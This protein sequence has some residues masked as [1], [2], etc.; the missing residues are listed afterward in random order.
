MKKNIAAIAVGLLMLLVGPSNSLSEVSTNALVYQVKLDKEVYA[1][2]EPI[3][4][5]RVLSNQSAAV[6]YI[7]CSGKWHD[8]LFFEGRELKYQGPCVDPLPGRSW[9]PIQPGKSIVWPATEYHFYDFS[10]EGQYT[11]RSTFYGW[12]SLSADN[13]WG[14]LTNIWEGSIRHSDILFRIKR[15]TEAELK[16]VRDSASK[17]E[18]AAIQILGAHKDVA[19]V[20]DLAKALQ[21][22]DGKKQGQA[23]KALA[24]I[25]TSEAV[26]ALGNAAMKSTDFVTRESIAAG[27]GKTGN[28]AAIPWLKELLKDNYSEVDVT[29]T[30]ADEPLA[31]VTFSDWRHH[32]PAM[33]TAQDCVNVKDP[34]SIEAQRLSCQGKGFK[35]IWTAKATRHYLVRGAAKLALKALGVVDSTPDEEKIPKK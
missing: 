35:G 10:R 29:Y 31:A 15:L 6:V 1:L 20:S 26:D 18:I 33:L 7:E 22:G 8:K 2:G 4:V 3:N 28:K 34:D 30:C 19:G 25:A 21:L 23:V 17:G 24:D 27:L 13:S 16:P 12:N 9:D 14:G 32:Y 5:A 11:L